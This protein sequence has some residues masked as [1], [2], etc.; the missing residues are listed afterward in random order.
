MNNNVK[1]ARKLVTPELANDY[2]SS[3]QGNR[4]LSERQINF[5][6]KQMVEGS[7]GCTGDT[8]K[9]SSDGRLLDGQHRL[10]AI[11]RYDKP[12]ECFIAEGVDPEVFPMIDTGKSRSASDVL[13]ASGIGRPTSIASTAKHVI[14]FDQGLLG[15]AHNKDTAPS[16]KRILE[17]VNNNPELESVVDYAT[18]ISKKFKFMPLYLLATLYWI[19]SHKNHGKA[20]EFMSQ[21][22][23]GI[24]LSEDSPVRLLRERLMKDTIN[25][26]KLSNRDRAALFIMCWNLFITGKTQTHLTLQKNYSFPK[27]I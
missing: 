12:V 23:S 11:I 15:T 26:K 27:P 6:Y 17:F 24:G 19:I 21:Y 14:I 7:W 9:I 13:S 20:H 18:E 3:N 10:H 8:I 4:K 22:G 16:H 1:V 5:Y 25:K 2:L